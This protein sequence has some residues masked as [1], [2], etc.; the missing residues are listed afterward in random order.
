[1]GRPI[2]ALAGPSL[3][4]LCARTE[5]HR[6]AQA[7]LPHDAFS[8]A[9]HHKL[10][11]I[12]ISDHF[13]SCAIRPDHFETIDLCGFAQA[14]VNPEIVLRAEAAAAAHFV[15]QSSCAQCRRD[16]RTDGAAVRARADK[17]YHQAVANG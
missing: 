17:L 8:F 14:H 6:A 16:A 5:V 7:A 2:A 9:N 3:L 12:K 4:S 15:D 13:R 1:M 10:I 11:G